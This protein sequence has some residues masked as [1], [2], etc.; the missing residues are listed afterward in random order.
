MRQINF[1]E[2]LDF[3]VLPIPREYRNSIARPNASIETDDIVFSLQAIERKIGTNNSTDSFSLDYRINALE[4]WQ[5]A[6][7]FTHLADTPASYSGYG[8][9]VIGVK[10][11]ESGLEFVVGGGGTS[12]HAL[13]SN[14]DYASAGH[15]GFAPTAHTQA[16][17]TITDWGTYI[18][19]A[20]LTTSSP[21]FA[22]LTVDSPTLVV[23]AANN[24]VGIGTANP[25]TTLHTVPMARGTF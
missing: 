6:A 23:D 10:S 5:D 21:S 1:P 13:L 12:N 2:E 17:S 16:S 7:A 20:L 19:Q 18:N 15:T 8:G 9:Y 25:G 24:R 4:D 14:L 22:G 11:D 3:S